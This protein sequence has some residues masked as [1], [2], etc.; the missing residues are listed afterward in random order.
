LLDL[1]RH[2]LSISIGNT[3][4]G[5]PTCADDI[6][7]LTSNQ[8]ELQ[9]MLHAVDGYSKDHQFKL[10]PTKSK[11]ILK[12][13]SKKGYYEQAALQNDLRLGEVTMKLQTET[14]LIR[15]TSNET[16]TN[17]EEQIGL[18]RRTLY[19][20]IKSGVHGTNGFNPRTSYKIYQVYVT[21]RL[22]YGLETL[23][24]HKKDLE[25][26][27]NFHLNTIKRLQAL[28][29]RTATAAVYLLL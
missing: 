10:H 24:L 14:G 3:Y 1:E 7:L 17:I 4:T 29:N 27:T 20:L 15:T 23:H 26:L 18:A 19:S 25:L 13:S 6:V 21:P 2:D 9:E 12:T 5:C 8:I 22:L 11:T 28:P 16:K